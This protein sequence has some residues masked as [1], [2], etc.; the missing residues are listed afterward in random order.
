MLELSWETRK[1][2]NNNSLGF[3]DKNGF[4]NPDQKTKYCYSRKKKELNEDFAVSADHRVK[5]KE[6]WYR[7]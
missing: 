5:L 2:Q 7:D 1:E 3:L 6:S 4:P